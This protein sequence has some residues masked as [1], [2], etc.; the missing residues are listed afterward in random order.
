M[1]A[2]NA[3][4]F[5]VLTQ[6]HLSSEKCCRT[7]PQQNLIIYCGFVGVSLVY[8]QKITKI[9]LFVPANARLLRF[10][11]GFGFLLLLLLLPRSCSPLLLLRLL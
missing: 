2:I 6:N 8:T 7:T 3:L 9:R 4:G 5:P 1:L 10:L 11:A